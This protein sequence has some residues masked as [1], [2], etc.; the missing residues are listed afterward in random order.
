MYEIGKITTT[1]GIKGE[2]KINSFSDFDRFNKNDV[3]YIM[4]NNE[5]IVLTIENSRSHKNA[6]IV[7][8]KEYNNINEVLAYRDLIVYSDTRGKLKKNEYY[9]ETLIGLKAYTNLNEYIGDINDVIELPHGHLLEIVT[10]EKRV[11]VPFVKEFIVNI[12]DE[13]V[14]IKPIEGLLWLLIL[15]QF[16]R[17]FLMNF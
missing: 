2:V 3:V 12:D 1:H 17:I 11:L 13:K 9:H 16:F 7:K 10:N 6:L 4:F 15:L 14:I 8:F 5:K